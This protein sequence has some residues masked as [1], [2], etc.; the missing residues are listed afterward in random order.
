MSGKQAALPPWTQ[1][2]RERVRKASETIRREP[3]LIV[4]RGQYWESGADVAATIFEHAL[5]SEGFEVVRDGGSTG[6]SVKARVLAALTLLAGDRPGGLAF[7][8]AYANA[9]LQEIS[10][11]LALV[12]STRRDARLA[13]VLDDV[14]ELAPIGIGVAPWLADIAHRYSFPIVITSTAHVTARKAETI[15]LTNFTKDDVNGWLE[16]HATSLTDE[17]LE[18]LTASLFRAD[19]DAIP[20]VTYATIQARVA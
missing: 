4:L 8:A 16:R 6:R 15:E 20:G 18:S 1:I 13:L 17:A 14:D 9:S 10:S 7:E 19:P 11:A 12:I 3:K 5:A 2:D